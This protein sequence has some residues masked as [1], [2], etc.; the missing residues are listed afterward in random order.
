MRFLL[1]AVFSIAIAAAAR[2]QPPDFSGLKIKPGDVIYVTE[3]SGVEVTGPLETLS[4][5]ELEVNGRSFTPTAGLKIQRRGDPIWDGAL[6]GLAAGMAIGS[7]V[8][9]EACLH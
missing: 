9:A 5:S 8:A 3:P 4:P 7:T 1:T 6:I 2:A